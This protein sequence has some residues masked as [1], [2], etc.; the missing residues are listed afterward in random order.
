MLCELEDMFCSLVVEK[1][2]LQ[3]E[4]RQVISNTI[5]AC[6]VTCRIINN[7]GNGAYN[8]KSLSLTK[9]KGE[10]LASETLRLLTSLAGEA[11]RPAP[12]NS[13]KIVR[14][15]LIISNMEK[16]MKTLSHMAE[17]RM[18]PAKMEESALSV[19]TVSL[20]IATL[21]TLKTCLSRLSSSFKGGSYT[22]DISVN[23]DFE[24]KIQHALETAVD[25]GDLGNSHKALEMI[26]A[27]ESLNRSINWCGKY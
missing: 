5:K 18:G 22:N 14:G 12:S 25:E 15:S 17:M 13:R 21:E 10:K 3:T 26:G 11:G 16:I 2:R 27:V 9:I 1:P 7:E 4:L 6:D 8:Q 19:E 24:R 20:T 23:I